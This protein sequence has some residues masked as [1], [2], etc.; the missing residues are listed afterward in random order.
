MIGKFILWHKKVIKRIAIITL[1]II[2][3]LIV[4][5]RIYNSMPKFQTKAEDA[6]YYGI[7]DAGFTTSEKYKE[8]EYLYEFL[9]D[10]YPFFTVNK[11]VNKIDWLKNKSQYKRKL[12]NAKGDAEYLVALNDILGDLN[13]NNTY[14]LT[15]DTYKRNYM[16]HYSRQ[17]KALNNMRSMARYNFNGDI[18]NIELD[19][20]NNLIYHNGPVLETEVLIENELAYMK[21]KAMAYNKIEE[22]YPKIKEFFKKVENY[23]KIIIDIRG[24]AG[25]SD[26]YWKQIVELLINEEHS[27]SYYSFFKQNL[28]STLDDYLITN[29]RTIKDLDD[30]IL[31]KF[32]KEIAAEFNFYKI[33][34]LKIN[35]NQEVN[36]KGKIYLLVDG[37]VSSSAEKFAAFA[38][39]TSFATL[40]GETTGGGMSFEEIPMISMPY[41]GF[42]INYSREMAMNSDGSINMETKTTPHIVVEDTIP[43]ED[44]NK[45]KCIQ[46]VILD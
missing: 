9:E 42:V 29:I 30:P 41:G 43:D 21:I 15:S 20:N 44:F 5:E 27:A 22:D 36:F 35:P 7:L 18:N 3:F 45:D 10:N 32:P 28:K 11:R 13:D 12:R 40:V 17:L 31:G 34:T 26:E 33:N 25:G 8:F 24:N 14:V 37:E 2:I 39:D 38:K 6:E 19:P 4:A 1:V 46:T 23:Y 16:Y